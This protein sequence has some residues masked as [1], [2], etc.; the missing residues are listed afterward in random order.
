MVNN[1]QEQ[2][3]LYL[4]GQMSEQEAAQFEAQYFADDELFQEMQ[5]VEDEM[6]D[7]FVRGELTSTEA[8]EFQK[9]YLTSRARQAKAGFAR[10]LAEHLAGSAKTSSVPSKPLSPKRLSIFSNAFDKRKSLLGMVAALLIVAWLG[11]ANLRMR[12]QLE[13]LRTQQAELQRREQD[14][15]KQVMAPDGRGDDK[16]KELQAHQNGSGSGAASSSAEDSKIA[17]LVLSPGMARSAEGSKILRL[18]SKTMIVQLRL[19]VEHDDYSAYSASI[20]ADD[21]TP[22][23]QRSGL[24]THTVSGVGAI[25]IRLPIGILRNGSYRVKLTGIRSDGGTEDVGDYT[26]LVM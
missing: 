26:F 23:W 24:K 11:F 2:A 10:V 9:E 3:R 14:L 20:K 6:L 16:N 18:S 5:G 25:T 19:L 12:H 8:Q 13:E 1:R 15:R 4:L 17:S 21:D 7:S 22:V